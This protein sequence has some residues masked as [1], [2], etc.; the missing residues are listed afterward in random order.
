MRFLR[1]VAWA[2]AILYLALTLVVLTFAGAEGN[3]N[4]LV[5][6]LVVGVPPLGAGV[7]FWGLVNR[8]GGRGRLTRALGWFGMLL[9]S[10]A[11]ISFSFVVW[12]LLLLAAPYSFLRDERRPRRS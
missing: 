5:T 7:Y 4:M 10:V 11:L 2:V 1:W 3:S 12:P 8:A 9:G 6:L